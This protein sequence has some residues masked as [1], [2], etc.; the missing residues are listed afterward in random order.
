MQSL[1]TAKKEV[2]QDKDNELVPE[3]ENV[4]VLMLF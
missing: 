1:L 3:I 4:D 2:N